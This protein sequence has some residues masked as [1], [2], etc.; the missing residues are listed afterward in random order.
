MSGVVPS[1]KYA[2][3]SGF[4]DHTC[5]S[6]LENCIDYLENCY[7]TDILL[8]LARIVCIVVVAYRCSLFIIPV[9]SPFYSNK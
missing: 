3:V 9:E 7:D 1:S 5:Y 2:N 8:V 4:L 6:S